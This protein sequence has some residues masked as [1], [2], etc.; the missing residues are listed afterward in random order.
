VAVCAA[1]LICELYLL[2]FQPFGRVRSGGS[3]PTVL[4][5]L[6]TGIPITQ[7][8]TAENVGL[9]GVQVEV[10]TSGSADLDLECE[11]FVVEP[12]GARRE[13]S[14]TPVKLQ[15]VS[16]RHSATAEFPP[17]ADSAGRR[18]A[19]T[20]RLRGE[21]PRGG[22]S[23]VDVGLAAF[24]NPPFDEAL[25]Q[26]Y[27][28]VGDRDRWGALEFQ[29]FATGDT[30]AGRLAYAGTVGGSSVLRHPWVLVLGLIL[31]NGLLAGVFYAFDWRRGTAAA[32]ETRVMWPRGRG[33]VVCGVLI[34][35]LGVAVWTRV[36]SHRGLDLI[37][38]L[39]AAELTPGSTIHDTFKL[40]Q[41]EVGVERRTSL[42][43]QSPSRVAWRV[44]VPPHGRLTAAV[45]L[46]PGAWSLPGDG[47]VFRITA[48]DQ[49][50]ATELF[51]LH[52][53]PHSL[54]AH[55]AWVPVDVELDKFAGHTIELIFATE[56]SLPG[57]EPNSAYDWALWG[58]PR[59]L[60]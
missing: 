11:M 43:A 23:R 16:G 5:E 17:V 47:V 21:R 55:R 41:P 45:A 40:V 48:V 8:F 32:S 38:Q 6:G 25:P 52:V 3:H 57:H 22:A 37:D 35:S 26:A 18:Y 27:L 53:N 29:T 12:D 4:S 28:V 31:Y 46:H 54:A 15:D 44:T 51:M 24:F 13:V 10:V 36:E 34:A 49:G 20:W 58:S 7:V 19:M 60:G 59:I 56:P 30:V 1:A 14:R 9:R 39:Y 42:F 33:L 50:T 2:A